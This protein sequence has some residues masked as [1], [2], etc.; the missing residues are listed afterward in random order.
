MGAGHYLDFTIKNNPTKRITA[1]GQNNTLGISFKNRMA[2]NT[3]NSG[4]S[5]LRDVTV[6]EAKTEEA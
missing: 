6:T 3:A 5:I 4:V 1:P 2:K